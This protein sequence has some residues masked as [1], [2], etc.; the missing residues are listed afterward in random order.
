MY[1]KL[2]VT[3]NPN[4]L[5]IAQDLNLH[6]S[7]ACVQRPQVIWNFIASLLIKEVMNLERVWCGDI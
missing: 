2:T 5:K 6:Y 7:K 1:Y 3:H 4:Q